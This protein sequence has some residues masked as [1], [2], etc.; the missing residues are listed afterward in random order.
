MQN[1]GPQAFLQGTGHGRQRG[2]WTDATRGWTPIAGLQRE[3]LTTEYLRP[4]SC[5][6][7][8]GV[9]PWGPGANCRRLPR[10]QEP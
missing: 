7:P 8:T 9:R 4:A 1:G 10:I 3:K 6:D 2:E 5:I